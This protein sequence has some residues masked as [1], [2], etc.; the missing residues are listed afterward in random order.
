MIL[1]VYQALQC[2]L[3]WREVEVIPA[4]REHKGSSGTKGDGKKT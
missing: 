3:Q 1:E 4:H 2:Q